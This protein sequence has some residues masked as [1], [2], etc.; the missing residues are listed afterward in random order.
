MEDI[1]L[2]PSFFIY[3][4]EKFEEIYKVL[5][6]QK[7]V[8]KNRLELFTFSAIVGFKKNRRAPVVKRATEMRTEQ[9]AEKDLV[10]LFTIMFN[11]SGKDFNKMNDYEY[12]KKQMEEDYRKDQMTFKEYIDP[13]TG[14]KN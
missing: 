6:D 11:E 3:R 5:I 9:L 13:F 1:K 4:S 10:P 2:T 14:S 8:F 7:N 12:I